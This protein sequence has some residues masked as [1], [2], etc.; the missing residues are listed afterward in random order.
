MSFWTEKRRRETDQLAAG[1]LLQEGQENVAILDVLE[2][3]FHLDGR[4]TLRRNRRKVSVRKSEEV[5]SLGGG[6]KGLNE[7][8]PN[9]C[10][11]TVGGSRSIHTE[12]TGSEEGHA[13]S[14]E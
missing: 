6:G 12:P 3:V 2:K 10:L 7:L 1:Q 8:L 5:V 14:T 13:R 4:L 11:W 9:T